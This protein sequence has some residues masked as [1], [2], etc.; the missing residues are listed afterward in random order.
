MGPSSAPARTGAGG[1]PDAGGEGRRGAVCGRTACTVRWGGAGDGAISGH[2][3][4]TWAPGGNPGAGRRAYRR[5]SPPRLL[6]TRPG[7]G[8]RRVARHDRG[9]AHAAQPTIRAWSCSTERGSTPTAARRPRRRAMNRA[10][11]AWL[12]SDRV[13]ARGT[14]EGPDPEAGAGGGTRDRKPVE[15]P[16]PEAGRGPGPVSRRKWRDRDRKPRATGGTGPGSW[17]GPCHPHRR[18]GRRSQRAGA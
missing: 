2:G 14:V 11:G 4:R 8:F 3:H 12:C 18:H 6:P 17:R 15:G 16:D 1:S 9:P 7:P 13:K 5:V 10:S